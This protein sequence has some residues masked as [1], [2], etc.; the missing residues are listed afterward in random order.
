MRLDQLKAALEA[1][2]RQQQLVNGLR[3]FTYAA[4]VAIYFFM[5][6][7]ALML[8]PLADKRGLTQ[9]L[10]WPGIKLSPETALYIL[11]VLPPLVAA[12]IWMFLRLAAISFMYASREYLESQSIRVH[13]ELERLGG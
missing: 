9:F 4:L 5:I 2:S 10:N 12:A 3:Y 11:F 6:P 1:E 8:A 7:I 13:K